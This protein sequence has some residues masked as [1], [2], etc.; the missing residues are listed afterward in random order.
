M[1]IHPC[2]E[3]MQGQPKL[4]PAWQRMMYILHRKDMH[5]QTNDTC[6]VRHPSIDLLCSQQQELAFKVG[7]LGS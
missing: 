1:L 3:Y 4:I 6:P 2:T 5:A 7:A